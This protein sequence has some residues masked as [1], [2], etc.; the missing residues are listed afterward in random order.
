MKGNFTPKRPIRI[1]E[2]WREWEPFMLMAARRTN[3]PAAALYAMKVCHARRLSDLLA[4]GVKWETILRLRLDHP[5]I[6]EAWFED[7]LREAKQRKYSKQ[8]IAARRRG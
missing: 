1:A 6:S 2:R 7:G 5:A 3:D 4:S 8:A